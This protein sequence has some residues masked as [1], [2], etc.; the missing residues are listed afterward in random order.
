[1]AVLHEDQGRLVVTV[2]NR[3][4]A[5]P[6]VDLTVVPGGLTVGS[7]VRLVTLVGETMYDQN[8]LEEPERI[9]PRDSILPIQNGPDKLHPAV[10][11][12][13]SPFS[14]VCLTFDVEPVDPPVEPQAARGDLGC[15]CGE[16]E[17]R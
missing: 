10:H 7:E 13:I 5:G 16:F 15:A 2:V 6:P 12:S 3:S 17:G 1:M 11:L 4:A 14:F 9:V 8:T